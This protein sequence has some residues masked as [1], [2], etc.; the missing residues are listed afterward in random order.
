MRI[1]LKE[2]RPEC[3]YTYTHT[4]THTHTHKYIHT[5]IHVYLN[6]LYVSE[7]E[8]ARFFSIFFPFALHWF[9]KQAIV[10][11]TRPG[12][13]L[14]TRLEMLCKASPFDLITSFQRIQIRL[15]NPNFSF[16]TARSGLRTSPRW[17]G[18]LLLLVAVVV[19]VVR[20]LRRLVRDRC[21]RGV[22]S[23]E[24]VSGDPHC[25]AHRPLHGIVMLP[26]LHICIIYINNI[27]I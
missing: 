7:G 25:V 9:V 5:Y 8:T 23:E 17:R 10:P 24:C 27:H 15:S 4:H 22:W 3:I 26:H 12:A 11:R 21:L 2:K 6:V 1:K 19:T 20:S 14:H 13:M 16:R 18:V